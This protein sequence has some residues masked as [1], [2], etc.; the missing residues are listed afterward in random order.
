MTPFGRGRRA[1]RPLR[2]HDFAS[3]PA[4]K[5]GRLT[6]PAWTSAAAW[7]AVRGEEVP[8][9]SVVKCRQSAEARDPC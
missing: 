5:P 7:D 2:R 1:G 4:V 9:L 6:L 3:W 8:F